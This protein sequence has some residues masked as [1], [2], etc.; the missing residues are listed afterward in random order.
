MGVTRSLRIDDA[1]EIELTGIDPE[2]VHFTDEEFDGTLV[3][4]NLSEKRLTGTLEVVN[5][6]ETTM[7][8]GRDPL[9]DDSLEID[10]GPGETRRLPVGGGGL[11]G[12][13]GTALIFGVRQPTVT[14]TADG[15]LEIDSGDRFAP[16]ASLVFWDRDF[17]RVN[18]QRPRRAQYL[19]VA[20]ALLS[21]V[22]AGAI[23]LLSL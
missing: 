16:L 22:L 23:V 15:T 19:S 14:E 5:E 20:F 21:A 11:V 7:G 17:Y 10:L 18:S 12:G 6:S 1:L 4:R 13:T 9:S 3:V 2:G 8:A